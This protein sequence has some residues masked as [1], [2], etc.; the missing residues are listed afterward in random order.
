MPSG[1]TRS[2]AGSVVTGHAACGDGTSH[3]YARSREEPAPR[4]SRGVHRHARRA[5]RAIPGPE[6][7]AAI[8][9][10]MARAG[11]AGPPVSSVLLV[12]TGQVGIRAARQLADTPG[13]QRLWIASRDADRSAELAAIMG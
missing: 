12:G 10:R 8:E 4:T 13:L 2:P 11:G 6:R 7:A 1:P 5:G 3:G 9:R